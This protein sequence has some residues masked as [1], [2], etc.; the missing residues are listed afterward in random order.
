[1]FAAALAILIT[2]AS[3]SRQHGDIFMGVSTVVCS[4]TAGESSVAGTAK[5]TTVVVVEVENGVV[6]MN[7]GRIMK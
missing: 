5:T 6:M 3:Q 4:G 7:D 2:G 1:G